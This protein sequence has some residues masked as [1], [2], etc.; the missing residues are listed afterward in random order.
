M[1]DPRQP[2]H[3]EPTTEPLLSTKAPEAAA[4]SRSMLNQAAQSLGG[5][6]V[7]RKLAQRIAQRKAKGDD[8]GGGDVHAAAEHGISGGGGAMPHLDAIQKSFG[9]HD[10]SGVSAHVG[11]RA[12]EASESMGAMAYATG[13]NVAF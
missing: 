5:A 12:A 10:V 4:P 1:P 6:A 8:A 7:Q 2:D 11:G 9:R 3:L 13:N